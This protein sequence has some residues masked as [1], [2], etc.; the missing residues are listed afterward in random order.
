MNDHERSLLETRSRRGRPRGADA[1]LREV[2]LDHAAEARTGAP[3]RIR[4]H[5][6]IAAAVVTVIA[7]ASVA[8]LTQSSNPQDASVASEDSANDAVPEVWQL[9]P[10]IRDLQLTSA[11][12]SQG[13]A[14]PGGDL[15]VMLDRRSDGVLAVAFSDGDET[16]VLDT[17]PRFQ[18]RA[19]GQLVTPPSDATHGFELFDF[20]TP[21][22]VRVT[23][24]SRSV[25]PRTVEEIVDRAREGSVVR[26]QNFRP[27]YEGVDESPL[28]GRL[29]DQVALIYEGEQADAITITT[30]LEDTGWHRLSDIE[31]FFD[32]TS[33]TSTM[34]DGTPEYELDF[35]LADTLAIGIGRDGGPDLLVSGTS[36]ELVRQAVQSLHLAAVP[37]DGEALAT[38]LPTGHGARRSIASLGVSLEL[39]ED[40]TIIDPDG[41]AR[42]M[43][44]DGAELV[45]DWTG[46]LSEE[47]RE[48][49]VPAG[50]ARLSTVEGGLRLHID[51]LCDWNPCRRLDLFAYGLGD[52]AD[53]EQR[54]LELA[55]RLV[56]LGPRIRGELASGPAWT[57]RHDLDR[58][59]CVEIG[60]V[61]LGCDDSGPVVAVDESPSTPRVAGLGGSELPE[62]ETGDLVYGFLP[63]PPFRPVD[64]PL[65]RLDYADGR[66]RT[67]VTVDPR[68]G[69]WAAT[70]TP[71]DLPLTVVY[72]DESGDEIESQQ[73]FD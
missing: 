11:A 58:G 27:F 7:L 47:G 70:V 2:E 69:L 21:D 16:T 29:F 56:V 63:E 52:G 45:P 37:A 33:S 6:L 22:G 72:F 18:A 68:T 1:I 9:E 62:D 23:V 51:V 12:S 13:T 59:L 65:V 42:F 71:G 34:S 40:W 39:P 14:L 55:E 38:E 50:P 44:S 8:W 57:V 19:S 10:G 36:S 67:D 15:T 48:V 20:E 49:N 32:N 53:A 66:Q 31:W 5:H 25:A 3:G 24:A 30:F 26:P 43:S 73:I 54:L 61:D 35:L 17:L 41:A 64:R 60:V 4:P 46:D 28:R